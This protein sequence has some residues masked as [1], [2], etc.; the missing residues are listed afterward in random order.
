MLFSWRID[1]AYFEVPICLRINSPLEIKIWVLNPPIIVL[2]N[3]KIE[4]NVGFLV[5]RIEYIF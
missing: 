1:E 4:P 3:S 5:I 2:F